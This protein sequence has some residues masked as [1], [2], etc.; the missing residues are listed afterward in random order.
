M[1][2]DALARATH[3]LVEIHE[4]F[5]DWFTG[6]CEKN[7]STYEARFM[8]RFG[9]KFLYVMPG[10]TRLGTEELR[11]AIWNGHGSNPD[12]RIAIRNVQVLALSATHMVAFYEE[13]QKGA[14]AS[15]PTDNGRLSTVVWL[16][17]SDELVWAHLQE[18]WMDAD[19]MA[20]GVYDF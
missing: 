8:K 6:R 10:G 1:N 14:K 7:E 15:T 19:A 18:T 3:E 9:E 11:T 4:F 16:R 12:F 2:A 20:K 5:V 13:W 17:N